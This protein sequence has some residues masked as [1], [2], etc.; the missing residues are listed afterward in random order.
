V[1][2]L[3]PLAL[4]ILVSVAPS[5]PLHRLA[6]CDGGGF[7]LA[8]QDVRKVPQLTTVLGEPAC[9]VTHVLRPPSHFFGEHRAGV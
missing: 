7:G 9:R 4:L 2:A 3:V 5:R 6:Q 8:H 1:S